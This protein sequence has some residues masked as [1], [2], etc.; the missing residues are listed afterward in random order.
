MLDDDERVACALDA[1][2][3]PVL[4]QSILEA[5]HWWSFDRMLWQSVPVTDNS[6]AEERLSNSCRTPWQ[7]QFQTV[8][9][10]VMWVSSQLKEWLTVDTFLSSQIF[11]CFDHVAPK[12]SVL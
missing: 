10:H 7:E 4:V 12:S 1:H 11:K 5:I 2:I 6:C 8:S 9:T 3:R